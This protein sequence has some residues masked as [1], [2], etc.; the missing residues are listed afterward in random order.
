MYNLTNL[1]TAQNIGD[2]T[3]TANNYSQG[4][5]FGGALVAV[6]F[7]MLMGLLRWGFDTALIVSSWTCFILGI[8]L[9]FGGFVTITL[10]LAFLAIAAF[11]TLF[12]W[13]SGR[14]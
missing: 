12:L 2:V 9:S 7:I 4:F 5:L 6:F 10:P 8:I 13:A 11:T 1:T 3:L 14:L